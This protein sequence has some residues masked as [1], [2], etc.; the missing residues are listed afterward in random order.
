MSSSSTD[1]PDLS[2]PN[3]LKD[4]HDILGFLATPEKRPLPSFARNG[5]VFDLILVD[6]P[7]PFVHDEQHSQV[8]VADVHSLGFCKRKLSKVVL[9][10]IQP[11]LIPLPDLD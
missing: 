8:W 2:K 7:H 10:I 4:Y 11:S 3:T 5:G 6:A 9:K 1:Q